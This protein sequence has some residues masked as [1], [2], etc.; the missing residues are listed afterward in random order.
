M[1]GWFRRHATI[2]MV[3]LGSAAMVIF[4]LGSVINSIANSAGEQVAENP[5]VAEWEGGELTRGDIDRVYR[6]HHESVRFLG[7]VVEA[8]EKKAGDSITPLAEMVSPITADDEQGKM[9]AVLSRMMMAQAAQKQGFVVSDQM[10]TE[11]ILLVSGDAQFSNRDLEA[12][13]RNVNQTSLEV[14]KDHL[15]VELLAMNMH[16]LSAVGMSLPPNPTEAISL[17][18]RTAERIE[19]E[20]IPIP[21][22]DFVSQ[23]SGTASDEELRKLYKEG[24]NE[25][26]DPYGAKPGFK[27]DRKINVQYLVARAE[28]F[29]QNEMNKITDEDV[30]KEYDRRVAKN[31]V[32][33]VEPTVKDNSFAFPAL[34]LPE[35]PNLED[36]DSDSNPDDAPV[37]PTDGAPEPPTDS[38]PSS[39]VVPTPSD[40]PAMETPAVETAPTTE[41]TPGV[42]V[43]EVEVPRS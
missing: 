3:V 23:V 4:G 27:V 43:P 16:G 1:L 25:L 21:V 10:V 36:D 32:S 42:E 15:K 14:V 22:K 8:A 34:N 5:T 39:D 28:T 13:N 12:I 9:S 37:P 29:L 18:G 40:A 35:L 11:Y 17:Y 2:L 30:Q 24:K 7:A 31:D 26:P 6:T 38:S 19:C 33:V 41:V 20:V